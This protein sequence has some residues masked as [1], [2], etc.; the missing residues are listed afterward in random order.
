M[1]NAGFMPFDRSSKCSTQVVSFTMFI[2]IISVM[3]SELKLE[4]HHQSS[5]FEELG[6]LW[7]T[8]LDGSSA[9]SSYWITSF[10]FCLLPILMSS[11][12]CSSSS[13]SM[14]ISSISERSLSSKSSTYSLSSVSSSSCWNANYFCITYK[15]S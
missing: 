11:S 15:H 7:L 5:S 3:W 8:N 13:S 9:S 2:V 1:C 14:S 10:S 12:S 4:L 6:L